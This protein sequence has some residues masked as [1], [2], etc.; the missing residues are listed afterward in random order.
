MRRPGLGPIEMEGDEAG[1]RA[2]IP[3]AFRSN[4]FGMMA[5]ADPS[6]ISPLGLRPTPSVS[7]SLTIRSLS[8]LPGATDPP[9]VLAASGLARSQVGL[10]RWLHTDEGLT[11]N[12]LRK[13]LGL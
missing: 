7:P 5:K 4:R 12:L 8:G 10:R 3:V 9:I 1:G 11:R 6:S 2:D 13:G